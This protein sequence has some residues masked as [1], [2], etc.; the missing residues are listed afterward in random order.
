[1]AT[2]ANPDPRVT[3]AS[4]PM[5]VI[6]PAGVMKRFRSAVEPEDGNVAVP[7]RSSR[8][9]SLESPS[10]NVNYNIQNTDLLF[11]S[12]YNDQIL[13]KSS[14]CAREG[15]VEGDGDDSGIGSIRWVH[16]R[17]ESHCDFQREF[18]VSRRDHS[19]RYRVGTPPGHSTGNSVSDVLLN[20]WTPDQDLV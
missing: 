13:G 11:E 6:Q 20:T 18:V 5:V 7:M 8:A 10:Y 4:V 2:S 15:R 16:D 3:T 14:A 17:I 9:I 12:F 1:M 19:Q